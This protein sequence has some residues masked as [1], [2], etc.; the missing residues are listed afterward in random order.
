MACSGSHFC[1]QPTTAGP[2]LHGAVPGTLV[3]GPPQIMAEVMRAKGMHPPQWYVLAPGARAALQRFYARFGL[4]LG[5]LTFSTG[6]AFGQ[7][8]LT[9]GNTIL[10][11]R[12]FGTRAYSEQLRLLAHEMT[13]SVQYKLLGWVSFLLR[14]K[15]EWSRSNGNPY[16]VPQPLEEIPIGEVDPVD[17]RF[18]LD[19]LADRFRLAVD[20]GR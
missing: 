10:L 13:H 18:Y 1:L 7:G 2:G 4:D 6:G 3:P 14:Y 12:E 8:G 5:R 16:G 11:F 9:L 17:P 19:Q 15:R 20:A